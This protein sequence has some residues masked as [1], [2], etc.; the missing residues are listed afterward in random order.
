M[1]ENNENKNTVDPNVKA[2]AT[3]EPVESAMK[4]L[5]LD[6]YGKILVEIQKGFDKKKI[7]NVEDVSKIFPL[8]I[9]NKD[10]V[11]NEEYIKNNANNIGKLLTGILNGTNKNYTEL[12]SD[13]KNTISYIWNFLLKK[14]GIKDDSAKIRSKDE[15]LDPSSNKSYR[16]FNNTSEYSRESITRKWEEF[17]VSLVQSSKDHLQGIISSEKLNS[18]KI[19]M[20]QLHSKTGDMIYKGSATAED[21]MKI[22]AAVWACN[23]DNS[24]IRSLAKDFPKLVDLNSDPTKADLNK[25]HLMPL[26]NAKTCIRDMKQDQ[27][28]YILG[29]GIYKQPD[30]YSKDYRIG[31][32]EKKAI[33][34]KKD[35]KLDL[36]KRKDSVVK[37]YKELLTTYYGTQDTERKKPENQGFIDKHLNKDSKIGKAID[38]V[39][40]NPYT[41]P[42]KLALGLWRN[43]DAFRK[44]IHTARIKMPKIMSLFDGEE[45]DSDN[46]KSN[47]LATFTQFSDLRLKDILDIL[48]FYED[49]KIT[50]EGAKE[51]SNEAPENESREDY[52]YHY[53]ISLNE[54]EENTENTENTAEVEDNSEEGSTEKQVI[55]LSDNDLLNIDKARIYVLLLLDGFL[56]SL[57][58]DSTG[59]ETKLGENSFYTGDDSRSGAYLFGGMG[60]FVNTKAETQ[61]ED[62]K[63]NT[64]DP[65]KAKEVKA[66]LSSY[67]KNIGKKFED[68]NDQETDKL[69]KYMHSQFKDLP[70][71]TTIKDVL[72]SITESISF[73][74]FYNKLYE[75]E[76]TTANAKDKKEITAYIKFIDKSDET[77]CDP[78]A[79]NDKTSGLS[80]IQTFIYTMRESLKAF[81][82]I[83]EIIE[84][85]LKDAGGDAKEIEYGDTTMVGTLATPLTN[86]FNSYIKELFYGAEDKT[87]LNYLSNMMNNFSKVSIEGFTIPNFKYASQLAST[88]KDFPKL[89]VIKI[90]MPDRYS[91]F[92]NIPSCLNKKMATTDFEKENK[93]EE[94]KPT[95]TK[96]EENKPTE[97]KP[98]ENKQEENNK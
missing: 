68:L 21:M 82:K 3:N 34:N 40:L 16:S 55:K 45:K 90:Q 51:L 9:L 87:L 17:A 74:S 5:T 86:T 36:K 47:D 23:E 73:K 29:K 53:L 89:D 11:V 67:L 38:N 2:D 65:N 25:I 56:D 52:L 61:K 64:I 92:S 13:N 43:R 41:A 83:G 94:N 81:S 69:T 70:K 96:Q 98:V 18:D 63:K 49:G 60:I 39:E 88:I 71:D 15:K 50:I 6:E 8:F 62:V 58:I 76:N 30:V 72:S 22:D 24:M 84:K 28:D 78:A 31:D 32:A 20:K 44:M 85:A 95:E 42:F 37:F 1:A 79:I 77:N 19:D 54:A 59:K 33:N 80:P 91:N 35:L 26:P 93:Q 48:K 4:P 66:S 7:K 14:L 46:S 97:N 75:A 12:T 27:N 10:D 57:V